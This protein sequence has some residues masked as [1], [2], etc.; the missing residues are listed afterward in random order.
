MNGS[1]IPLKA[2]KFWNWMEQ[3]KWH[4]NC[5]SQFMQSPIKIV[6]DPT[7]PSTQPNFR[8]QYKFTNMVPFYVEAHG[9]EILVKFDKNFDVGTLTLFYGQE[10]ENTAIFT[11]AFRPVGITFRFPAE[12]MVNGNRYDGEIYFEFVEVTRKMDPVSY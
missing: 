1:Y 3:D 11:K 10:E 4:G 9:E 2:P 5:D 12:H 6:F 8:L 7:Q